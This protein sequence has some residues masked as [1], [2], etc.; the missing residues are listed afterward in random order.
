MALMYYV[1]G[2]FSVVYGPLRQ[3]GFRR[4]ILFILWN[5]VICC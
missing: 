4:Q 5:G 2:A 3:E 1:T